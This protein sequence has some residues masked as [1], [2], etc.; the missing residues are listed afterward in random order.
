MGAS[1]AYQFP[2]AC[3]TCRH[4]F[5]G[6]GDPVRVQVQVRSCPN[7]G[8]PCIRLHPKF[9][10]PRKNDLKQWQ[11]V[12]FLVEH[13]FFFDSVYHQNKLVQYPKSLREAREFVKRYAEHVTARTTP[14]RK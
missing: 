3:F 5:R 2:Y 7:C 10:A 11:K 9:K 12:Q 8:G 6:P 4:V 13:G 1:L 14:P